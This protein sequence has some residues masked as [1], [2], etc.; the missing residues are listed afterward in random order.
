MRVHRSRM[1]FPAAPVFRANGVI[2][3]LLN[4]GEVDVGIMFLRPEITLVGR[5]TRGELS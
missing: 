2:C 4:C 1:S 5:L 3:R